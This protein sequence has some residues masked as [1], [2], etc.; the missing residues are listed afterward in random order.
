M[1]EPDLHAE[2]RAHQRERVVDVVA[3]ADERQR[4]PAE[5]AEPLVEREQVGQ[6]LARVLADR[7]AVD[8]RDRGLRG[9]LQ[10]DLVRSRAGHD[11]VHEALE[12]VGDVGD[13]LAAAEHDPLGEVD[14]VP[15]ELGHP[16]LERDPRAQARALEEHGERPPLEWRP[17]VPPLPDEFV[18][19][20]RGPREHDADLVGAEISGGDEVPPAQAR[21]GHSPSVRSARRRHA[22]TQRRR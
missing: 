1:R 12:V 22:S 13:A 14:R 17:G 21:A 16:G 2:G 6:R 7:Q 11:P 18:L 10:H 19:E 9:E 5:V 15:A 8:D 4:Q 20:L 3:V